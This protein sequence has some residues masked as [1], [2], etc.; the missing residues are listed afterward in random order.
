MQMLPDASECVCL[1][2]ACISLSGPLLPLLTV[3]LCFAHINGL[4]V[5]DKQMFIMLCEFVCAVGFC[6][7]SKEWVV[8]LCVCLCG[9]YFAI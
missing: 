4:M 1:Y 9:L 5:K 2:A 8:S 3:S 6:L 7:N